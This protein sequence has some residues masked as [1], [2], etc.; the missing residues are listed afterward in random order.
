MITLIFLA[1]VPLPHTPPC[2]NTADRRTW[3][4]SRLFGLSTKSPAVNYEKVLPLFRKKANFQSLRKQDSNFNLTYYAALRKKL[5]L[6]F[7]YV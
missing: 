1:I 2:I 7:K 4:V 6:A 3:Q 5:V